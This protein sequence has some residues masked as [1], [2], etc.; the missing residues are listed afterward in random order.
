MTAAPVE[1]PAPKKPAKKKQDL[2]AR[3]PA[4]FVRAVLRGHSSLGLAFAALIYLVCLSGSIAVFAHEFQRWE[5]AAGP[6]V[7]A[8]SPDAVQTAFAGAI[9]AGGSGVEHV[10]LTLPSPDL[11]RFLLH[12]DAEEDR[13]FLADADGKL[14]PG[15]EFAWTEFITRLHINL[16]LP[17]TWGIF[18]VGLVGVALLSS[19]ISGILA[20]PRIFR[21]A[22]HLRIGGSKRLQE[23]DLHNR[24]GVWAL[25]FHVIISLTGAFLG[26]TTIV[27][28]VLGMAMFNGDAGKVYALFFPEPPVDDPHPAPVLDLRPMFAKLPHDG[29]RL[30]YIF[31]EHPTERGGAALF[32]VKQPD[33]L[34]G[35]DSYA[36]RRAATTYDIGKASDNN[37]GEDL[38]GGMGALHF[39]WFGGGLVKIVYFLLGLG[40]TYLAAGGVNIWLARRRDKGRPAPVWE[41]LWSATLWGQPAGIAAAAS[42]ALIAGTA[43]AAIATWIAVSLLFWLLAVRVDAVRLGRWGVLATGAL[44]LLAAAV[45]LAWRGGAASADGVAWIVNAGLLASGGLL[46]ALALRRKAAA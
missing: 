22:F 3:I 26:L 21:D 17:V 6:Q 13:E 15:I 34:A 40:L 32:N 25:P 16:H 44:M 5:S 29:G 10:Y 37:L 11:P 8:V 12:V 2:M 33:R 4:G 43:G 1:A 24:L 30:T 18:I 19:L 27:V 39:G 28:G 23:A 31:T 35:T 7:S 42:A 41:R 9:A 36:F 46:L 20:H 45:H 38:L 14:V